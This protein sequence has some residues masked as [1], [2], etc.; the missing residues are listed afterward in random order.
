MIYWR[1]CHLPL[2]LML[3]LVFDEVVKVKGHCLIGWPDS[4]RFFC[5]SLAS[6]AAAAVQ[7]PPTRHRTSASVLC[8]TSPALQRHLHM[9]DARTNLTNTAVGSHRPVPEAGVVLVV[10]RDDVGQIESLCHRLLST[11]IIRFS[12]QDLAKPPK[13]F[14]NQ[15]EIHQMS[16]DLCGRI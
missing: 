9:R 7:K 10:L 5:R 8:S 15:I 2:F 11:E 14:S 1:M 16:Q 6:V 4:R 12:H 3:F 13:T